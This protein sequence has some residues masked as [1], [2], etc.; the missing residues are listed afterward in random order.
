MS[1]G[2]LDNWGRVDDDGGDGDGGHHGGTTITD[3]IPLSL[4]APADSTVSDSASADRGGSD[5]GHDGH[6]WDGA[7]IGSVSCQLAT[8][9]FRFEAV[10]SRPPVDWWHHNTASGLHTITLDETPVPG[11]VVTL[12]LTA[13]PHP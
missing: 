1:V 6:G 10:V 8:L 9:T 4:P 12:G 13:P 11:A 2:R 3:S 5:D 7:H